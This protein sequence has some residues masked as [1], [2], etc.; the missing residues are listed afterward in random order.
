MHQERE[1]YSIRALSHALLPS[2]APYL[3]SVAPT[4]APFVAACA[5][6]LAPLHS[7]S[8]SL[9]ARRGYEARSGQAEHGS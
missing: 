7:Y 5:P 3:A 1:S 6:V 2:F 8:L 9:G 4:F